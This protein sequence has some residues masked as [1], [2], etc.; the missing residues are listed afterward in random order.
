[1]HPWLIAARTV[2]SV[3]YMYIYFYLSA[4]KLIPTYYCSSCSCKNC[5]GKLSI[6]LLFFP[7]HACSHITYAVQV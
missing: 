7:L 5:V 6:P 1:M 2:F 3:K 4:L